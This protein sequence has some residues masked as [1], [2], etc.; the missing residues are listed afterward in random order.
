[1]VAGRAAAIPWSALKPDHYVRSVT[2]PAEAGHYA[3]DA[4]PIDIDDYDAVGTFSGALSKHAEE[5]YAESA[6]AGLATVTRRIF[7]ALTD[8]VTDPRGVRRPTAISE[9]SAIAGASESDVIRVVEVFRRSGR[10][11]LMPPPIVPLTSRSIVDLSHE[12][13]MRC[14]TRLIEWAGEELER[15]R[16]LRAIVARGA[17]VR[18]GIRRAV[19]KSRARAGRG[20]AEEK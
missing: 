13:L 14:W 10:S 18:R 20:V 17:M 19:A 3:C 5:A 1:M 9:L 6:S 16:I 7:Q 12:S 11:F 2:G 4:G 8:T 15:R